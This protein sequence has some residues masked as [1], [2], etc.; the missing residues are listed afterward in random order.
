[1][2]LYLFFKEK[3]V[4]LNGKKGLWDSKGKIKFPYPWQPA[5]RDRPPVLHFPDSCF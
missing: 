3:P 2:V 5:Q 1:M 4:L